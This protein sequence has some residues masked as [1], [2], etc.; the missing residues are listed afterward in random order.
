MHDAAMRSQRAD[1]HD[2]ALE[3]QED[4]DGQLPVEAVVRAEAADV[5]QRDVD[6]AGSV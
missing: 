6:L 3:Q 2:G 1:L 4:R 5:E